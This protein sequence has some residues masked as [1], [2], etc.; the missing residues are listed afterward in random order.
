MDFS[1]GL[2]SAER[3]RANS[4]IARAATAAQ[5]YKGDYRAPWL[6]SESIYCETWSIRKGDGETRE[7]DGVVVGDER[8][9]WAIRLP[10]GSVL[11]EKKNSILLQSL[12][13]IGFVAR[14]A[15]C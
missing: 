13:R 4:L 1:S 8:F 10:D 12:Q 2:N 6:L 14:A 3:N 11:T 5:A 9:C 15:D 7:V